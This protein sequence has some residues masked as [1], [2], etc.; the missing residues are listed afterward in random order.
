MGKGWKL[1][2]QLSHKVKVTLG[3]EIDDAHIF[4]IIGMAILFLENDDDLRKMAMD[5]LEDSRKEQRG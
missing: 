1:M 2:N 4:L 3:H 5:Y